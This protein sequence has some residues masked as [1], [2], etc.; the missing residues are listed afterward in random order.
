MESK[1]FEPLASRM[2]TER[3]S[4]LNY[5]PEGMREA[6]K[7][8]KK[9]QNRKPIGVCCRSPAIKPCHFV[10]LNPRFAHVFN[11]SCSSSANTFNLH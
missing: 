11:A 1:G 9:T 10:L 6:T 3:S 5:D 2:Q 4:K 8:E 7:E